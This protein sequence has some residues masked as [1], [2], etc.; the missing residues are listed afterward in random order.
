MDKGKI[1]IFF[2]YITLLSIIIYS[3]RTLIHVRDEKNAKF[4]SLNHILHAKQDFRKL[5]KS[6]TLWAELWNDL[7]KENEES[8]QNFFDILFPT[9]GTQKSPTFDCNGDGNYKY[10]NPEAKHKYVFPYHQLYR[11]ISSNSFIKRSFNQNNFSFDDDYLDLDP[12]YQE[13]YR[14]HSKVPPKTREYQEWLFKHQNPMTCEGKRFMEIS[15]NDWGF[16]SNMLHLSRKVM[17]AIKNG[18]IAIIQRRKWVWASNGSFCKNDTSFFCFF[19]EISNCTDYYYS[20]KPNHNVLFYHDN[21][22]PSPFHYVNWLNDLLK[23]TPMYKHPDVYLFYSTSQI[24]AYLLRPNQRLLKWMDDFVLNNSLNIDTHYNKIDVAMHIR[25]G[26]KGS[27]MKL[28]PTMDYVKALKVI[29]KIEKRKNLTVYVTT[30]DHNAVKELKDKVKDATI[31]F[32][33]Q[34]RE[35]GG[36]NNFKRNGEYI[37]LV[38][39]MNLR[40]VLRAKYYIGTERSCWGYMAY[41]LRQTAGFHFSDQFFEVGQQKCISVCHCRKIGM[42]RSAPNSWGIW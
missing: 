23:D 33:D 4:I 40:E 38:T 29:Q 1:E 11:W 24:L 22:W 26:D 14:N 30:E 2:D 13:I 31:V 27:E 28:V 19:E 17:L 6:H 15:I 35:N 8:I 32:Y 37:T 20:K 5:F 12:L 10:T 25:H 42:P 7:E 3:H 18:Y 16:G 34:H 21:K 39:M 36:Y 41:M 9:V